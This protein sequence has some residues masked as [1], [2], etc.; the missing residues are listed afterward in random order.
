[1][2]WADLVGLRRAGSSGRGAGPDSVE[3]VVTAAARCSMRY[4]ASWIQ[5]FKAAAVI[6]EP[7]EEV[8]LSEDEDEASRVMCSNLL[9]LDMVVNKFVIISSL[10]LFN[11]DSKKWI[12]FIALKHFRHICSLCRILLLGNSKWNISLTFLA[13]DMYPSAVAK[14]V[15]L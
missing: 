14:V 3:A 11:C 9:I 13:I 15:E 2:G 10:L 8:E 7:K 1:M 5:G 4:L 12:S 6:S